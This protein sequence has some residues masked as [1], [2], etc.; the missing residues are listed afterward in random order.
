MADVSMAAYTYKIWSYLVLLQ[1]SS[2]CCSQRLRLDDCFMR[3]KGLEGYTERNE[4][5]VVQEL[6][7]EDARVN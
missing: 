2:L 4:E 7:A 5:Y 1:A 3:A 6:F